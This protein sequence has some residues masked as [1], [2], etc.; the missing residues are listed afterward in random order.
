[1]IQLWAADDKG[2]MSVQLQYTLMWV[3]IQHRL[4]QHIK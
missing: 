1:M 2:N 4:M 3:Q